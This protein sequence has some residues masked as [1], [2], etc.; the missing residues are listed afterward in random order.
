M[1]VYQLLNEKANITQGQDKRE[2]QYLQ[3]V[4]DLLADELNVSH[5]NITVSLNPPPS[6]DLDKSQHGLTIGMGRKP[7]QIFVIID[8]GLNTAEKVRVLAHEMVH[9]QQLSRGDLAILEIVSGKINGE[10][11]GEK[12]DFVRYSKSNPWEVEA[13]TREKELHQLVISKLGQYNQ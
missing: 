4:A 11:Q 2:V 10:W 9:V 13:Y 3:Q 6:L 5:N 8:R 7:S 1:K 12:F